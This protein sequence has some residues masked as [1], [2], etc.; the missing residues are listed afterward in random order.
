VPEQV[1][2]QVPVSEPAQEPEQEPEQA[3]VPEQ[4]PE[5]EQVSVSGPAQE[6]GSEQEQDFCV[7]ALYPLSPSALSALSVFYHHGRRRHI[8]PELPRFVLSPEPEIKP[9]SS[10]FLPFVN[11]LFFVFTSLNFFLLRFA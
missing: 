2:E 11:L 5:P 10:M 3:Q 9:P 1:P 4:V 8:Q 6:Q 7:D